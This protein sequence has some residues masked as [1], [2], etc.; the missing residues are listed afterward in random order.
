[1]SERKIPYSQLDRE[2]QTDVLQFMSLKEA[3]ATVWVLDEDF[4][5]SDVLERLVDVLPFR[6]E[7]DHTHVEKL[8][9][10]IRGSGWIRPL[11][12]DDIEDKPWVE[13]SHRASAA[14]AMN[15]STVPV[16]VRVK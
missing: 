1:M 10:A 5:L 4:R 7:R 3:K 12:V 8:I 11:M 9:T 13:G 14:E 2:S 15:L 6:H 16:L